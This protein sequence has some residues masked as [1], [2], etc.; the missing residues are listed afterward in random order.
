M[1]PVSFS[2]TKS[3]VSNVVRLVPLEVTYVCGVFVFI[4]RKNVRDQIKKGFRIKRAETASQ[5]SLPTFEFGFVT[6]LFI[7]LNLVYP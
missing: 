6:F 4:I 7:H 1:T 5:A 3:T 2:A